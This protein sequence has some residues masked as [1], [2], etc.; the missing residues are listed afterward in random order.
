MKENRMHVRIFCSTS[1][2]NLIIDNNE[3]IA[4]HLESHD[5]EDLPERF[6]VYHFDEYEIEQCNKLIGTTDTADV[7]TD[8]FLLFLIK[9]LNGYE[10]KFEPEYD[11][12]VIEI[13]IS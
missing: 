9:S 1:V 8:K 2:E 11:P 10:I 7:I 3:F 4:Y 5:T 12:N 13:Q 6:V